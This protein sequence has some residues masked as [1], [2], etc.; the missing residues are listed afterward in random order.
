MTMTA[1]APTP[2]G[3]APTTPPEA[4]SRTA[5][6]RIPPKFADPLTTQDKD[7]PVETWPD[8]P[9]TDFIGIDVYAAAQVATEMLDFVLAP[10]NAAAMSRSIDRLSNF[11]KAWNA[12]STQEQT[13][14]LETGR[15][16]GIA[17]GIAAAAY[18]SGP[19]LFAG[20]GQYL[21]AGKLAALATSALVFLG[22]G[23][24]DPSEDNG[25][26]SKPIPADNDHD[27]DGVPDFDGDGQND[28]CI[29]YTASDLSPGANPPDYATDECTG[30]VNPSQSDT[31]NDGFGDICDTDI[32][33]DTVLN[34][35]DNCVYVANTNQL[36]T[37][38]SQPFG[39]ACSGLNDTD[40]DGLADNKDN[41]ISAANPD[42][43][44]LD[45]DALGDVCDDDID[46]D[47]IANGPDNCDLKANPVQCDS[48]GDGIGNR[49]D[50]T[51]GTGPVC[52]D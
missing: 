24:E 5:P 33:N 6:E 46:G 11:S 47:G 40:H 37:L 17:G 48:D 51:L 32:D 20:V 27:K 8:A 4:P 23:G 14:A 42:Q 38:P 36:N 16:V 41:C 43:A 35:N 10:S 28:K 15:N 7:Q 18:F 9:H 26:T 21:G 13:V 12:L 50:E 2:S 34:E 3:S 52:N 44:N 22:C 19:A 29:C 25:F 45:N 1:T 31:D 30:S 39:D 49:C